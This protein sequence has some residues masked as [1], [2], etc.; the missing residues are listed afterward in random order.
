MYK[1]QE[2]ADQ[3]PMF[4]VP[5]ALNVISNAFF[6]LVGG[7]GLLTLRNRQLDAPVHGW[8]Y[9]VFFAGIGLIG[10]GSG[11][12]H[13]SPNNA[14]LVWDRLPMTTAFM[15]FTALVF[16]ERVSRSTGKVIFPWLIGMGLL[17]VIYWAV[18]DDLRLYAVVQF[19]PMLAL[20]FVIGL[21]LIHI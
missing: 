20:P 19:I 14:T 4:W 1:R 12:Y 16:Y 7:I 15:A 17:S 21:S 6:L 18:T 2:F 5:H 11:Y 8:L 3:R 13:W 10:L 9:V